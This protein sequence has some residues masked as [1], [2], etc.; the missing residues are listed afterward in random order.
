M[1]PTHTCTRAFHAWLSSVPPGV[2]ITISPGEPAPL[3]YDSV[4][5][6]WRVG[7]CVSANAR[8]RE[9]TTLLLASRSLLLPPSSLLLASLPPCSFLLA[10]CAFLCA[11][12]FVLRA[13]CVVLVASCFGSSRSMG[14]GSRSRSS[15]A[16]RSEAGR[17]ARSARAAAKP[18][19]FERDIS[20]QRTLITNIDIA[21]ITD[22]HNHI[23][24]V[25]QWWI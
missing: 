1:H 6:D 20:P 15:R 23:N 11:P 13:L 18:G 5:S 10:S 14:K 22:Q 25:Y 8:D 3:G 16:R 17:A 24:T 21:H 12:C 19:S 9:A 2:P 4:A 7:G